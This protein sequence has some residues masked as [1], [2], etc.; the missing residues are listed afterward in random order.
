[1]SKINMNT[2]KRSILKAMIY[3]SGGIAVL[4]IVTWIFTH[5]IIQVTTVTITYHL[6][7]VVGYYIYERVWEH[8]RWGK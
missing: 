5:D 2:H 6:V 8:V 1:M 4:A 7:S 3:R